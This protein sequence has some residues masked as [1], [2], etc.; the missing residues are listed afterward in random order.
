MEQARESL[1]KAQ[2][3]MR[4]YADK[5]RRSLEFQVGD[6]VLLKLTP[7]IWKKVSDKRYHNGLVQRYD[8]P[9]EVIKRV[10]NVVYRLKLP[11]RMKVHPM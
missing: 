1:E 4:K 8:G 5:H 10:D 7:Q 6:R 3:R 11:E 2:R 9:F